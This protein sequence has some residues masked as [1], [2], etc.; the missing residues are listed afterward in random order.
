[1]KRSGHSGW[2]RSTY[3]MLAIV[4]LGLMLGIA[5]SVVR[6]Q[7]VGDCNNSNDVTVDE[8]LTMVNIALGNADVSTCL[9]GDANHDSMIT[10]DEILT[11]VNNALNGC[12][13]TPTPT[14]TPTGGIVP[15]PC[16]NGVSNTGEECDDGGICIGGSKAGTP[17]TS[18]DKCGGSAELGVCVGGLPE[19]NACMT[20]NDCNNA[21]SKCV[22]CRPFGGD[23]CAANCTLEHD[24][25]QELANGVVSSDQT[26]TAGSGA[27]VDASAFGLQLGLALGDSCVGGPVG[28]KHG[29]PCP[30]GTECGAGGVCTHSTSVQTHGSP[31]ADGKITTVIKTSNIKFSPIKVGSIACA[32]VRAV[33][34]KTCGGTTK[35]LDGTASTNC[36]D[37]YGGGG[38]AVCP[39]N[40]P[41]TSVF[42]PGNAAGGEVGC[43]GLSDTS[44][45][46]TQDHAN[47]K[48]CTSDADCAPE[49]CIPDPNTPPTTCGAPAPVVTFSSDSPPKPGATRLFV[50]NAIGTI[51]GPCTGSDVA[52]GTDGLFCTDDDPAD[53]PTNHAPVNRGLVNATALVTGTATGEFT[54]AGGLPNDQSG[55][56][57][58]DSFTGNPVPCERLAVGDATGGALVGAFTNVNQAQLGDSVVTNIQ[59]SR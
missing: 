44:F 46:I 11:A 47:F 42:G 50:S 2:K 18:D 32:C 4:T 1:M 36:T 12:P 15:G 3:R 8:L 10:I 23:G 41:C 45:K 13:V 39:A 53:P 24:L 57:G 56:E 33:E 16:G 28:G 31:G 26:I 59:V 25:T 54:N 49:K 17:C 22:R 19:G 30:L 35:E 29:V 48:P 5:P 43:A 38:A 6:A 21:E 40:R 55:H 34:F 58:P 52:Y 37:G 9:N 51:V 20:D 27:F 7:C 14:A